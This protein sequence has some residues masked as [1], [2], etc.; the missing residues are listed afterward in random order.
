MNTNSRP[1]INLMTPDEQKTVQNWCVEEQWNVNEHDAASRFECDSASHFMMHIDQRPVSSLSLI[2]HHKD[3]YTLGPFIVD[4]N[5]RHQGLGQHLWDKVFQQKIGNKEKYC[6]LLCAVQEQV[7]RYM[8]SE[9][10]PVYVNQHWYFNSTPQKYHNHPDIVDISESK[11]LVTQ[12]LKYD[13]QVFFSSRKKILEKSIHHPLTKTLC[14]VMNDNV[15][16]YAMLR[17]YLKG[18]RIGAVV[19]DNNEIAASLYQQALQCAEKLSVFTEIPDANTD[20]IHII[21]QLGAI[22]DESK[23]TVTMIKQTR[24]IRLSVDLNRYYSIFSLETG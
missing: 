9:F 3:F 16:G 1:I 19:A 20:A 12:I 5:F 10:L 22:H 4:K 11:N 21:K 8:K 14:Y 15:Q 18:Y 17:P 7:S 2:N 23:D 13:E 24:N 6:I